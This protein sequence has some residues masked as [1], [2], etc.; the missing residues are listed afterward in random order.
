MNK[1]IRPF[2]KQIYFVSKLEIE[3]EYKNYIYTPE[4]YWEEIEFDLAPFLITRNKTKKKGEIYYEYN[5]KIPIM[6]MYT[7]GWKVIVYIDDVI[8]YEKPLR[9][10]KNKKEINELEKII[11]MKQLA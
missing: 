1:E 7:E 4:N 9:I 10:P 5:Y 6:G 3:E 11:A 8:G 2:K